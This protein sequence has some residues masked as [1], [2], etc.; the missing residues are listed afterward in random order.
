VKSFKA[1]SSLDQWSFTLFLLVF[2]FVYIATVNWRASRQPMNVQLLVRLDLYHIA[3][4]QLIRVSLGLIVLLLL[5]IVLVLLNLRLEV[6][7]VVSS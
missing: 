5:L 3:F 1:L 2:Q 7:A 4:T 6:V